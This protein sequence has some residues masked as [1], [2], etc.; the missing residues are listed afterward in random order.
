[1]NWVKDR[2]DPWLEAIRLLARAERQMAENPPN[3]RLALLNLKASRKAF[4]VVIREKLH[5]AEVPDVQ[6]RQN[7]LGGRISREIK[8]RMLNKELL[9]HSHP[10]D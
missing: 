1:M 4:E 8:M 3:L 10:L 9:Q 7:L 2:L 5:P 6:M